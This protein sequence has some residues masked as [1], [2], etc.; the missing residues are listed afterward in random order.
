MR[1]TLGFLLLFGVMTITA[2]TD[3]RSGTPAVENKAGTETF[4]FMSS[5][6]AIKGKV[7]LPATYDTLKTLPAIYLVDFAEQHFKLATD[8]FETVIAAVREA[9]IEALVVSLENIPE[10]D[11]VPETFQE[12]YGLFRDMVAFV[13][14]QYATSTNRTF[15]GRGSEGGIVLMALFL[16]KPESALFDNF[17]VTD[18]SPKYASAIVERMEKGNFPGKKS[19]KRLH[20]SF[21]ASNN[22]VLCNKLIHVLGEAGYPWL[23]F[24]T[25][26]YADNDYEHTYP[27][28]YAAGIKYVFGK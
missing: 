4:I 16:E 11:A 21:S 20:F 6:T 26:E 8:E 23:R 24:E 14:G 17:V 2:Q 7:Y 3:E 25:V 19:S 27:V 18:P 13:D 1:L 9:G 15:V 10:F 22:R 12:H 5:G 28:S